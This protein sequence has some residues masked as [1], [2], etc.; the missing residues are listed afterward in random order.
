MFVKIEFNNN[1]KWISVNVDEATYQTFILQAMQK[2]NINDVDPNDVILCDTS[3]CQIENDDFVDFLKGV[4][5]GF[6]FRI[7]NTRINTGADAN[8]SAPSISSSSSTISES[9]T[10]TLSSEDIV[11]INDLQGFIVPTSVPSSFDKEALQNLLIR[12]GATQIITEYETKKLLTRGN[13]RL[14]VNVIV[15]DMIEKYG[16]QPLKYIK[17]MYAKAIIDLFPNLRDPCSKYGY[18][19]FYNPDER[20]GYIDWR[21]RTVRRSSKEN[22]PEI[23]QKKP[24][25]NV[26]E[27]NL[28]NFQEDIDYLKHT[29]PKDPDL[30]EKFKA[31]FL[32]RRKLCNETNIFQE[33]PR[34]LDTPGLISLDFGLLYPNNDCINLE[35]QI[36][37]ISEKVKNIYCN[38][39]NSDNE[40]LNQFDVTT[41][42]LFMLIKLLPATSKGRKKAVNRESLPEIS[43]RLIVFKKNSESLEEIITAKKTNQPFLIA[44]GS[45]EKAVDYYTIS[46]DNKVL[47]VESI[48]NSGQAFDLLFKSFFVFNLT[49]DP[50]LEIFYKFIQVFFYGIDDIKITPNIRELRSKLLA[51]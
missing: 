8:P 13:R 10:I 22:R 49:Y 39:I 1:L 38:E 34:F 32:A 16:Q 2:F 26:E 23:P 30:I 15:L 50:T 11:T 4:E 47:A 44:S 29:H 33:F 35:L 14:L 45:S 46:V 20:S 18:E 25:L 37:N 36:L 51:Q 17:T 41:K 7:V 21:L 3:G 28:D 27:I 9:T 24:K 31:T 19:A 43:K 40:Y 42:T 5:K 6:I 48:T 12:V